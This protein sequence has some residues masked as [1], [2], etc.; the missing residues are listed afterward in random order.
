[1]IKLNDRCTEIKAATHFEMAD[2]GR[3]LIIFTFT[4]SPKA[5][6]PMIETG[7]YIARTIRYAMLIEEPNKPGCFISHW[8]VGNA[9]VP[10]NENAIV[11]K[12]R[13]K[14][15]NLVRLNH[16]CIT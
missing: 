9:A 14:M 11:P 5:K 8:I 1:M 15:K 2:A 4:S 6:K 10:P 13:Y 16:T 7:R 3:F 12:A